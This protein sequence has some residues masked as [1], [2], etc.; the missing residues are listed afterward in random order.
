MRIAVNKWQIV[1]IS[2]LCVILFVMLVML[3]TMVIQ[4][5]NKRINDIQGMA[6]IDAIETN[7]HSFG[8]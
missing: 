2:A 4:S 5:E 1:I 8:D 6:T 7:I 3:A